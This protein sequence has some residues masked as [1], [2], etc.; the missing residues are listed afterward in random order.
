MMEL[1]KHPQRDG[2]EV[3]G[4]TDSLV[5]REEEERH[6]RM[7]SEN[8]QL[9]HQIAEVG[10]FVMQSVKKMCDVLLIMYESKRC[11][12]KVLLIVSENKRCICCIIENVWKQEVCVRCMIDNIQKQEVCMIDY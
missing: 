5:S 1:T 8:E 6:Q 9:K 7:V 11:V 3:R 12:C 2:Q 4:L 10:T